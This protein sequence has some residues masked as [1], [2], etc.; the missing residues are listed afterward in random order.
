M[1]Y[2]SGNEY[3]G[4]WKEDKKEGSG[5]MSW[6]TT[7]ERYEGEWKQDTPWGMGSYYWF[8][9]RDGKEGRSI[10]TIFKGEWKQGQREGFGTF[11]YNNGCRL[12][13]T[14]ANNMKEGVCFLVDEFG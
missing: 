6:H 9:G 12:E 13:G 2:Q 7:L 1:K 14:F 8:E 5:V 4:A 10:K 3:D 11:F